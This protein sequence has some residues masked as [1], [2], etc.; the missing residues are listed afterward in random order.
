ME[1]CRSIEK[2]LDF[3]KTGTGVSTF[4][5]IGNTC[6]LNSALQTLL[7]I[8]EIRKIFLKTEKLRLEN[9]DFFK[10]KDIKFYDCIKAVYKGYW[11]DDC[12]IRPIGLV[13]YLDE[14]SYFPMGQQ[15]DSTEVLTCVIQKIHESVCV[16][17][18]VTAENARSELERASIKQWNLYLE[19]KYSQLVN[20][21]W[22]QFYTRVHCHHCNNKSKRF[23]TFHYLTLQAT[24][25]NEND[26][27]SEVKLEELFH[28]F[29]AEKKFD[30]D[31]KYHCDVCGKKVDNA[32]TK[33][34][35]WK[36]PKYLVIQL[37]RYYNKPQSKEIYKSRRNVEYPLE[38]DPAFLVDKKAGVGPEA[39]RYRLH[40]GVFHMG[41]FYGG[42]Y[43]C[44]CW[45]EDTNQWLGFDDEKRHELQGP[46]L[47]NNNIYQLVY[48]MV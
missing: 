35:M 13:R 8:E 1:D 9:P 12:L 3:K 32:T 37:K 29:R 19:N 6:Y 48:R 30:E 39:R 33:T 2:V 7:H 27:E 18:E 15:S 4:I 17:R 20:M 22:G 42:H 31:N 10:D 26:V 40:S 5:N 14:N 45:N 41:S 43:N 16:S 38:F 44:F 36:L 28:N 46:I 11:E 21:F 47:E 24:V 23:E 25:D 34:A